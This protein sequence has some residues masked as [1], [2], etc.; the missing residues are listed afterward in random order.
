MLPYTAFFE[1]IF[2]C[3]PVVWSGSQYIV[4]LSEGKTEDK[5]GR[6]EIE[7]SVVENN[8]DSFAG[9]FITDGS[10]SEIRIDLFSGGTSQQAETDRIV[11]VTENV[12]SFR[13]Q[14]Y[15]K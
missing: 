14:A 11:I 6:S 15:E 13:C 1:Y 7:Q 8:I 9:I 10:M 12:F 3:K 2:G 5:V 4:G